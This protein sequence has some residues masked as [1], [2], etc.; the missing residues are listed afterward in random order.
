MSKVWLCLVWFIY[1]AGKREWFVLRKMRE[2]GKGWSPMR[3]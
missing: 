1:E 2:L 3:G